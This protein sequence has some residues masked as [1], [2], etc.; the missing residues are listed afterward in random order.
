MVALDG[1]ARERVVALGE[2]A[3]RLGDLVLDEAAHLEDARAELA[4]LALVG[5]IGVQRHQPNRPVM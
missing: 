5:A 1:R 2:R 3:D 4:E